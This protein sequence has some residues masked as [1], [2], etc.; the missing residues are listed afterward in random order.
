MEIKSVILWETV[1]N[2]ESNST[3]QNQNRFY[4][5]LIL[6][7]HE[8]IG[9]C[10]GLQCVIRCRKKYRNCVWSFCRFA[11]GFKYSFLCW[12]KKKNKTTLTINFCCSWL[13]WP[14]VRKAS[15]MQSQN[16]QD[17][18]AS[19]EIEKA[20]EPMRAGCSGC[21]HVIWLSP[22]E[23]TPQHLHGQ[24]VPVLPQP[25][26]YSIGWIVPSSPSAEWWA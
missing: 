14:F 6:K 16:C 10:Y 17:Q 15:F 24:S 25:A 26:Q 22:A 3:S 19:V 4:N 8:F 5:A 13:C 18:K 12:L 9:F 23:E 2:V 20:A 11:L 1:R 21:F 7:P